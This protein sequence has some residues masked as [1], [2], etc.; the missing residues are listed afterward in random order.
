[1]S[2]TASPDSILKQK[3]DDMVTNYTAARKLKLVYAPGTLGDPEVD[4]P[5]AIRPV[6]NDLHERFPEKVNTGS[7]WCCPK[8]T[9]SP[10]YKTELGTKFTFY[11]TD[12]NKESE[13][14]CSLCTAAA[15]IRECTGKSWNTTMVAQSTGLTFPE[16]YGIDSAF[17]DYSDL[18]GNPNHQ[19]KP[20]TQD[21]PGSPSD[22]A[23]REQLFGLAQWC[24]LVA[25]AL[26]ISQLGTIQA[27]LKV[28]HALQEMMKFAEGTV[29]AVRVKCHTKVHFN[30]AKRIKTFGADTLIF[31]D[32]QTDRVEVLGSGPSYSLRPMGFEGK[33]IPVQDFDAWSIVALAFNPGKANTNAN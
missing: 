2:T 16:R 3:Y 8:T 6:L 11:I 27:P 31:V 20:P 29:F 30:F 18:L 22:F 33:P 4:V 25:G 17:V 26:K 1:M 5:A 21:L 10:R 7:H 9:E 14:N 15:I 19:V 32:Y 13:V 12:L 23:S 24:G 28:D